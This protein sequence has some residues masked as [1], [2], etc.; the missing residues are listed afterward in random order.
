MFSKNSLEKHR[1]FCYFWLTRVSSNKGV[2]Y[3]VNLEQGH[4]NENQVRE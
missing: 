4:A 2:R 1:Y 3:S